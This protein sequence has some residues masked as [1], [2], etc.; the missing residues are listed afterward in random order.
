MGV[1]CCRRRLF[2]PGRSRQLAHRGEQQP[3]DTWHI[4]PSGAWVKLLKLELRYL[5]QLA[6]LEGG[7][8]GDDAANGHVQGLGNVHQRL[9]VFEDGCNKLVH[10][11]AV[12]AA[13]AAGVHTGRK[14]WR[15]EEH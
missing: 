1:P 2:G 4:P 11:V 3:R 13:V 12:R 10:E 5:L 14:G 8:V 15:S 7:L 6:T 9:A